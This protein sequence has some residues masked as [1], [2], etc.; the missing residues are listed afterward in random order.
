MLFRFSITFSSSCHGYFVRQSA[1]QFQNPILP[2]KRHTQTMIVCTIR[3][4]LNCRSQN[5]GF[6]GG[7]LT[8]VGWTLT[9][10]MPVQ[11]HTFD[12]FLPFV[13]RHLN[14]AIFDARDPLSNCGSNGAA[15]SYVRWDLTYCLPVQRYILD[16]C[17][18]SSITSTSSIV[19]LLKPE[20]LPN[21]SISVFWF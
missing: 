19:Q 8:S 4:L 13:L 7:T 10:F 6:D 16:N 18:S 1:V 17:F 9:H 2:T 14:L 11:R 21:L 3:P 15:L 5:S 20:A 12:M